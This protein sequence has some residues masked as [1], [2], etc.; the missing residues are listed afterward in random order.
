MVYTEMAR[1]SS[2]LEA[3]MS[4]VGT[5]LTTPYPDFFRDRAPGTTTAGLTAAKANLFTHQS[6]L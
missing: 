2:I 3:A 4:K 1:T 5:P 6:Y